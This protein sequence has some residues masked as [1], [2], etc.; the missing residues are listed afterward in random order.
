MIWQ[1]S[2]VELRSRLYS[3]SEFKPRQVLVTSRQDHIFF[4]CVRYPYAENYMQNSQIQPYIHNCVVTVHEGINT[5]RF[6][7]FFKNHQHLPRNSCFVALRC[8][9]LRGDVLV[10]RIGARFSYVNM[11]E[12]DTILVDWF[13]RRYVEC[14]SCSL[15]IHCHLIDSIRDL[16]GILDFRCL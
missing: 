1:I 8:S 7:V 11:R 6:M 16:F 3:T 15:G 9:N 4:P 14:S 10:M 5:Y 13:M 2:E 12:R